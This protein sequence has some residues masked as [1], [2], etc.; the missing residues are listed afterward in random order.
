M[1]FFLN[2]FF[3]WKQVIHFINVKIDLKL[4]YT[5]SFNKTLNFERYQQNNQRN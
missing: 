2:D 1:N 3:F 5:K 4:R